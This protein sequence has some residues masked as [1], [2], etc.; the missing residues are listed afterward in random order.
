MWI[1]LHWMEI[2]LEK[3]WKVL[4]KGRLQMFT[5][6][7][8]FFPCLFE[9]KE[10]RD[11]IFRNG[12]SFYGF[13]GIYL[14]CCSLF[15]NPKDDIPSVVMVWVWIPHHPLHYL[16]LDSLSSIR[17]ALGTY[18]DKAKTIASL[19][20]C[21]IICVEVDLEKWLAK[22]TILEVDNWRHVYKLDYDQI[23]FERKVFHE[24]D[25][26]SIDCKVLQKL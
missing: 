21:A 10:D 20:A 11:L 26:F 19:F 17:N 18:I 4:I 23:P 9:N 5:C 16:G 6:R 25:H 15:F 3:Y 24:Y 1:Y 8:G 7:R 2:W 14:N 13:H 12:P 22:E